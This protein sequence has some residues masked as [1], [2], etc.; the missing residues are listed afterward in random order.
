MLYSFKGQK[1]D[2]EWPY[3]LADLNGT[4]YGA[5]QIGGLDACFHRPCGT[6]FAI[7]TSGV[8][9]LLHRFKGFK[10]GDGKWPFSGPVNVGGTLYGATK[11]GGTNQAGA[12]YSITP[13]GAESVI[14]SF[15]RSADANYPS[16]NPINVGGTLYGTGQTGANGDGAVYAITTSGVE[17]VIYSF[18]GGSA[19]GAEPFGSLLDVGGTLY[20]TTFSGG[21]NGDG[22]VFSLTPSGQEHVL[23]SFGAYGSGDG[24]RPLAGLIN[25]GGTLY[26]TTALGGTAEDGTVFRI[27]TSGSEK[28]LHSFTTSDGGYPEANL[29][30]LNGTIYGTVNEYGGISGNCTGGC[31]AIFAMSKSGK[32]KVL[33][34]FAGAPNDGGAPSAALVNVNG[35][36]YGTTVVGG[37]N[38]DGTVFT[39]K[40]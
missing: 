3:G 30:A 8:E 20:G 11:E 40:P 13:S 39:F 1:T 2:G 38:N 17:S 12:V 28:V 32:L 27:T 37:A 4:I 5:T 25:V 31:G 10:A 18:K 22:T 15:K 23:H 21:T 9:S 26:G 16:S 24:V 29:T 33:H 35:T 34:R 14:Y 6:I 7:T 19:D 36:L